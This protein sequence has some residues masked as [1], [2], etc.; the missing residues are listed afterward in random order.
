VIPGLHGYSKDH[1]VHCWR[2][3]RLPTYIS[4]PHQSYHAWIQPSRQRAASVVGKYFRYRPYLT[5][6]AGAVNPDFRSRGSS[7]GRTTDAVCLRLHIRHSDK[8]AGQRVLAVAE[9]LPYCQAVARYGQSHGQ[10]VHIYV[11][12]DSAQVLHEILTTW[13]KDI[14]SLI[15]HDASAVRSNDTTAVFDATVSKSRHVTN[16][17]AITEM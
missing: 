12:T 7:D 6:R 11:A 5:R 16:Q 17:D 10:V 1:A 2:Y 4:K 9:F 13:P 3:D 14:V 8:A 15:R